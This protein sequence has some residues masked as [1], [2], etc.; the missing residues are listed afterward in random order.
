MS[1][2]ACACTHTYIHKC[3]KKLPF[4]QLFWKIH[5]ELL[6]GKINIAL[7][8]E[9]SYIFIMGLFAFLHVNL[10]ITNQ[11]H[12]P[13]ND[14][15]YHVSFKHFRRVTHTSNRST[16]EMFLKCW[17]QCIAVTTPEISY[18]RIKSNFH[19]CQT[20]TCTG[21]QISQHLIL[22]QLL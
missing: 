4:K 21:F 18:L 20:K 1:V 11:M 8:P 15:K 12:H 10:I 22:W 14:Q 5:P 7:S 19:C 13:H 17:K 9:K 2:F 6:Q 16:Q 3:R